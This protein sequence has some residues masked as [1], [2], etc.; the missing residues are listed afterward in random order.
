MDDLKEISQLKELRILSIK[1]TALDEKEGTREKIFKLHPQIN[2]LN[3][4][5]RNGKDLKERIKGLMDE[6]FEDDFLDSDDSRQNED[7]REFSFTTESD[8]EDLI[9]ID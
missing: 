6:N 4:R 1:N 3:K 5:D 8:S 7:S 2:Y 9:Y